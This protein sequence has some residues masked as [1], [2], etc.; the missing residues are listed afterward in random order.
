MK[1]IA[2]SLVLLT[3]FSVFLNYASPACMHNSYDLKQEYDHKSW[4]RVACSCPCGDSEKRK[5]LDT[6]LCVKCRHRRVER[7]LNW[8]S[9]VTANSLI[10]IKK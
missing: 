2:V 9:A 6:G 1:R 3:V 5:I 10:K 7:P 8:N 4:H